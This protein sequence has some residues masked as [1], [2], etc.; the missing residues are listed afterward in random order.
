MHGHAFLI[1][2][3]RLFCRLHC[4]R[5]PHLHRGAAIMTMYA[6][7]AVL[8]V[9]LLVYLVFAMLRPEWF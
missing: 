9:C 3:H 2:R 1:H 4:H 8:A 5:E 7:A 6:I